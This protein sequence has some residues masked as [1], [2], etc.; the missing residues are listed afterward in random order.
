[1]PVS[2]PFS[3]KSGICFGKRQRYLHVAEG[4]YL[5]MTSGAKE[6]N[7]ECHEITIITNLES[8]TDIYF[9]TMIVHAHDDGYSRNASSTLN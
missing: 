7:T 3:S 2:V 9:F 5:F 8:S 1:M 4:K 6:E